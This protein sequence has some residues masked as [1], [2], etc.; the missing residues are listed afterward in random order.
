MKHWSDCI[1][2][3]SC[4]GIILR[5]TSLCSL[6]ASVFCR[7]FT[8]VSV[9]RYYPNWYS[10]RSEG[11]LHP[12]AASQMRTLAFQVHSATEVDI[13]IQQP[14]SKCR[15]FGQVDMAMLV[16]RYPSTY[17]LGRDSHTCLPI[18]CSLEGSCHVLPIASTSGFLAPGTYVILPLAFNHYQHHQ[19]TDKRRE[20]TSGQEESEDGAIPYV[21]AVFSAQEV[22]YEN[23]TTGPGF[24]AESLFLLAEKIGKV[25]KVCF[26]VVGVASVPSTLHELSKGIRMLVSMCRHSTEL[27]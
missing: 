7:Y 2:V 13:S 27:S 15:D 5:Y 23:I 1:G 4:G 8:E 6:Q 17:Q 19:R 21:A 11:K 12:F 10:V 22:V 26:G 14:T 16:L 9:C 18:A 3:Q 25:S 24:L 20:K